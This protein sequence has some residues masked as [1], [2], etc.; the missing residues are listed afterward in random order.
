MHRISMVTNEQARGE[1]KGI[2]AD[3]EKKTG[4][5]INMF[6]VLGHKPEVLKAFIPLYSAVTGK[7]AVDQK[8]KEF[9]YLKTAMVNR[10]DY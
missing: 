7:G 9:V 8:I 10:C 6:R 1:A 4:S 5:V 2:F 3:L